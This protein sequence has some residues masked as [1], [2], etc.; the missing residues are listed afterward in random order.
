MSRQKMFVFVLVILGLGFTTISA[1][2]WAAPVAK[3]GLYS[4]KDSVSGYYQIYYKPFRSSS[5]NQLTFSK[6]NKTSPQWGSGS[7]VMQLYDDD[8][9]IFHECKGRL[10]YYLAENV[11]SGLNDVMMGCINTSGASITATYE[12]YPITNTEDDSSGVDGFFVATGSDLSYEIDENVYDGYPIFVLE[13]GESY[14]NIHDAE[15]H[16]GQAVFDDGYV[17][18]YDYEDTGNV[19]DGWSSDSDDDV[20]W[21]GK[22]KCAKCYQYCQKY[23][24]SGTLKMCQ[25][26]SDD[27]N[28]NSNNNENTQNLDQDT[29]VDNTASN[30]SDQSTEV[31]SQTSTSNENSNPIDIYINVEVI[32]DNNSNANNTNST[33][34]TESDDD[35]TTENKDNDES[36]TPALSENT[37]QSQS[38]PSAGNGFYMTG[39]GGCSLVTEY[40][41]V[42]SS[43]L[44]SIL[45]GVFV[46]GIYIL[47][48][49]HHER[50]R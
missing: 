31:N 14:L 9:S 18:Q 35:T 24:S 28:S 1:E 42:P 37:D 36:L 16:T 47:R 8:N 50:C 26:P 13:N 7:V 30:E 34:S 49:V 39:G 38:V 22:I 25:E 45:V 6:S 40:G 41:S 20:L 32:N 23:D 27:N 2:S 46:F 43:G 33:T 5:S 10:F 12:D 4:A 44:A 48:I 3:S 15:I 29:T 11:T 21:N 19:Y 17:Q